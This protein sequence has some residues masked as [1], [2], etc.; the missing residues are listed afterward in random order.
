MHGFYLFLVD[1]WEIVDC[2]MKFNF[3]KLGGEIFLALKKYPAETLTGVLFFVLFCIED[4]LEWETSRD[5]M[6][7][8]THVMAL[9]PAFI[10]L[11]Y[12]LHQFT[13][14][15][16]VVKMLYYLSVLLPLPFLMVG[17]DRFV[18]HIPYAFTL[19]L[20]F[21]V[22]LACKCKWKNQAFATNAMQV[23]VSLIVAL[24]IGNLI[25]F[26]VW[27]L[28]SAVVYIFNVTRYDFPQYVYMLCLFVVT[29]LLFFHL[30]EKDGDSK[31]TPRFVKIIINYILSPA[32][33]AYTAIL[34][35][36][37]ITIA[38][39]WELPKGGIGYMVL[40]FAVFALAG[41]LSQLLVVRNC[42]GWFYKHLSWIAIPP[43]IL[44]W[45]GTVERIDTYSFTTS[46][47]YLLVSGL[48]MTLFILSLISRK[49]GN[50]QLMALLSSV[51]LAVLTFIPGISARD[52]G[53]YSQER[54]LVKYISRLDMLD[55][56]THKLKK[57]M[58]FEKS[59]SLRWIEARELKAS[60]SYL[61]DEIGSDDLKEKY[62]ECDISIN[63]N[64]HY[65]SPVFPQGI[66]V[67][68]YS[69]CY[70]R[71]NYEVMK[72]F[73]SDV[74][75]GVVTIRRKSDGKILISRDIDAY[76]ND[77]RSLMLKEAADSVSSELFITRND[78]CMF[79]LENISYESGARLHCTNATVNAIFMR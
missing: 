12:G 3:S 54:R 72:E 37:F 50:Y 44:F 73:V 55:P 43:L 58:A 25:A 13:S 8:I 29:P 70:L 62:G 2:L 14:S 28:Y 9:F 68:G 24:F 60:Y 56:A 19:V 74:D 59:D 41:H 67:E 10:V 40:A 51:C 33:I 64:W 76:L 52:I 47:V 1:L 71:S 48:L 32:V 35:L 23:F 38:I 65:L 21:F 16:P 45:I 77:H 7:H 69:R 66:D 75:Q 42:Y 39:S 61:E 15:H 49:L 63:S 6:R 53:I 18:F 27:G 5:L 36:Y 34:Y 4:S 17:L 31:S 30:Q 78:S 57:G 26:A 46:R 20:S 79:V 22:L 11:V